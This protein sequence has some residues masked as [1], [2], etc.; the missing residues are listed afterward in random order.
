VGVVDEHDHRL[1]EPSSCLK[2][3]EYSVEGRRKARIGESAAERSDEW[4]VA[5]RIGFDDLA[6]KLGHPFHLVKD[7]SPADPLR[8]EE[9]QGPWGFGTMEHTVEELAEMGHLLL[10]TEEPRGMS[11]WRPRRP[12]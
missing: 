1:S 8:A 6:S 5:P 4:L 9:I 7:P 12:S 10:A 11:S 3:A 2:G